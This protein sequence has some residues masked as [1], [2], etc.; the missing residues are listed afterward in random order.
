MSC[1]ADASYLSHAD[2]KSHTGIFYSLTSEGPGISFFSVKQKTIAQSST[3][4]ELIALHEGAKSTVW[5]TS[6]IRKLGA[7]LE[8]PVIYQDNEATI[9][10]AAIG[11]PA[12]NATKHIKMKFFTIKEYTDNGLL[13]VHYKPTEDMVG[14]ILTKPLVGAQFLKF[15][16]QLLNM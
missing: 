1:Q 9:R 4:S 14:D 12:S 2:S 8:C 16:G 5:M 15:R 13:T 3:E 6:L 11:G 10:L 7:Q